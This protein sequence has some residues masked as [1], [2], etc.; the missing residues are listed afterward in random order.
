MLLLPFPAHSQIPVQ[1]ATSSKPSRD[2]KISNLDLTI[3]S[4]Q[5]VPCLDVPELHLKSEITEVTEVSEILFC[6]IC[7]RMNVTC[8]CDHCCA[9][10]QG[11]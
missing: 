4:K 11:L 5:D 10:N 3:T 9:D 2:T 1:I 6:K 7:L 8:E